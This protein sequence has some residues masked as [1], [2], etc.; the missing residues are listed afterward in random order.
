M[1]TTDSSVH[2]EDDAAVGSELR[3]AVVGDGEDDV[4]DAWALVGWA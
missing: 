4:G 2:V 3:C 1:P